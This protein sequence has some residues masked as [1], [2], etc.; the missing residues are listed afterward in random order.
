MLFVIV[1]RS[2]Y[3]WEWYD[4]VKHGHMMPNRCGKGHTK[5]RERLTYLDI[6]AGVKIR[7]PHKGTQ[8][9][10]FAQ[11]RARVLVRTEWARDEE[12][13]R[14]GERNNNDCIEN[15]HF[16]CASSCEKM[17]AL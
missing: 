14:G 8:I 16:L 6:S 7:N 4:E 13:A 15:K 1:Q 12:Q 11:R 17:H 5:H 10:S 3:K 2:K 9:K